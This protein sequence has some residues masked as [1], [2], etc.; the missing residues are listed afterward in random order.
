[1]LV[2]A[3][4]VDVARMIAWLDPGLI[5]DGVVLDAGFEG[6]SAMVVLSGCVRANVR[7]RRPKSV[8]YGVVPHADLPSRPLTHKNPKGEVEGG[9]TR[10]TS[11]GGMITFIFNDGMCSLRTGKSRLGWLASELNLFTCHVGTASASSRTRA[12]APLN[13]VPSIHGFLRKCTCTGTP[14]T[15]LT[16]AF[17]LVLSSYPSLSVKL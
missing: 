5:I 14:P 11:M 2:V 9:R 7:A 3:V 1:M 15:G 8:R 10:N 17:I 16:V 13:P 6:G 4:V 12:H